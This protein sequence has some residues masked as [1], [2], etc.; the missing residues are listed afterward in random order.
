MIVFLMQ[1]SK[2]MVQLSGNDWQGLNFGLQSPNFSTP[3]MVQGAPLL[4]GALHLQLPPT[5]RKQNTRKIKTSFY[6]VGG[7]LEETLC[8][9][10]QRM[11]KNF[12]E[13]RLAHQSKNC[14][15]GCVKSEKSLRRFQRKKKFSETIPVHQSFNPFSDFLIHQVTR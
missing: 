12:K 10:R 2:Y 8:V 14:F 3:K 6:V 5:E 13:S 4:Q 15:D 7:F 11:C 1:I 9:V